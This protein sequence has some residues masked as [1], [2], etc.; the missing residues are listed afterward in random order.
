VIA[1]FVQWPAGTKGLYERIEVKA[2]REYSIPASTRTRIAAETIRHW[3]KAYPWI[4]DLGSPPA[5]QTL[6]KTRG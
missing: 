2:A 1:E 4:R 6:A 5:R 3:L